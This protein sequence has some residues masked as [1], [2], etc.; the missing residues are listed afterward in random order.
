MRSRCLSIRT[1]RP[2]SIDLD[3]EHR[4]EGE[5]DQR[6]RPQAQ[7]ARASPLAKEIEA[8]GPQ[9]RAPT[10]LPAK[11]KETGSRDLTASTNTNAIPAPSGC[12]H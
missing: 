9:S 1:S 10:S 2:A 8:T 4:A 5:H 7:A 6:P 11:A 12:G 3:A